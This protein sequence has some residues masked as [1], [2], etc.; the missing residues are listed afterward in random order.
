MIHHGKPF[1]LFITHTIVSVFNSSEAEPGIFKYAFLHSLFPQ[2]STKMVENN[3][4]LE[5]LLLW[6]DSIR[7]KDEQL[8]KKKPIRDEVLVKT[9]EKRKIIEQICDKINVT[10]FHQCGIYSGI[11]TC[12]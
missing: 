5:D 10:H 8:Q 3:E 12:S 9:K 7:K 2:Y 6:A 1:T 4:I 11:A